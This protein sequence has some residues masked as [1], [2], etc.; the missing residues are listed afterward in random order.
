MFV[1]AEDRETCQAIEKRALCPRRRFESS[2]RTPISLVSV[3][4]NISAFQGCCSR[5]LRK[6]PSVR[7][8]IAKKRYSSSIVGPAKIGKRQT[9]ILGVFV[10]L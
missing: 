5:S 1:A 8:V 10:N 4:E 9:I 6:P 2:M 3:K 7:Q